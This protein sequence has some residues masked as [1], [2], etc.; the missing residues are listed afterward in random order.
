MSAAFAVAAVEWRMRRGELLGAEADALIEQEDRQAH[1]RGRR[2][3]AKQFTEKVIAEQGQTIESLRE[4]MTEQ[5]EALGELLS[6]PYI[7]RRLQSNEVLWYVF[8]VLN[9]SSSRVG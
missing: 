4:R 5:E 8:W 9:Q 2:E 1:E 6:S 3:H 7:S